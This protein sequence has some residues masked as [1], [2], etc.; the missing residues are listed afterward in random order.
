MDSSRL[1]V[2]VKLGEWRILMKKKVIALILTGVMTAGLLAGCGGGDAGQAEMSQNTDNAVVEDAAEN[3]EEVEEPKKEAEDGPITLKFATGSS[4]CVTALNTVFSKYNEEHPNVTVEVTV[5]PGGVAGFNSAMASK[6]AAGD[7]PDLFQYQWGTQINAYAKGGN[8]M[9]LTDTGIRDVVQDIKKPMNVYD[10]KD[11]A[12][13][14]EFSLWGLMYNTELAENAGVNETPK[15]FDEFIGAMD[16]I[17][18]SGVE[19]PFIVP[20]K[21][22]SGATGF[23]FCYLHQIVSGENPEFYYQCCTGDKGWDGE[24]WRSLF[25]TYAEILNYANPDSLGLDVDNALTRFAR[26]EG[27]FMVSGPSTIKKLEE[28][29]PELEGKLKY[30]PFPLYANESEYKTIADFDSCISVWSG[31]RYPEAAIDVYKYLYEPENNMLIAESRNA[32]SV[33][34]NADT[35]Y[36]DASLQDQVHLLDEGKYVGYSEREWIPGIKEI[37]K[38]IV[39]EWIGGTDLDTTLANL[40]KEHQRLLD[41]SPEFLKEFEELRSSTGE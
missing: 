13:P 23:V 4:E 29:N 32:V 2:N 36:V 17:R 12:Y 15:T 18:D 33:V 22:G 39:Q 40:Q 3:R 25:D 41:A 11:Y 21:D 24:E 26:Q 14:V 1:Y 16:K 7:A 5:L 6:L 27:A 20:A 28:M 9:D 31:T 37:M 34:K 30:I 38:T 35:S 8:L 10:G 19:Y